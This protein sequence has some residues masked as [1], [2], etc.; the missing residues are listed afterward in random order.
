MRVISRFFVCFD[1]FHSF[2]LF[3]IPLIFRGSF[4]REKSLANSRIARLVVDE[5][6]ARSKNHTRALAYEFFKRHNFLRLTCVPLLT[7][8]P[9]ACPTC[10][11]RRLPLSAALIRG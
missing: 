3:L 7:L 5:E 1:R 11:Y 9:D 4:I 2:S 6:V 10:R 8:F